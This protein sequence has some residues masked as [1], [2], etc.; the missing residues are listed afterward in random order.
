MSGFAASVER[1][2]EA[3]LRRDGP[4]ILV[5]YC[6]YA[7]EE[8]LVLIGR[9]V[10]A[11]RRDA[12]D[13]DQSRWVN[14]K[15]MASLF[16]TS[17]VGDVPVTA[18]SVTETTDAEGYVTLRV[19]R[20]KKA[21]GWVTVPA[22]IKGSADAPVEMRALVPRADAAFGVISDIDDTMMQT[23]AHNLARNLWT[24]F[25]GNALTRRVFPDALD[26][27]ERLS[28]AGRN[29]VFYVSSSPWNLHSFLNK[30]F[31]RAGLPEGPMFL[32]DLGVSGS[33]VIGASHR[34]HKGQA[35]DR[36]IAANPALNFYL[37]GDTGQKDALVYRDA[38]KRYP[39][40][41]KA[42][43]L[44][45]P[46][47]GSA[48]DSLSALLEIEAMGVPTHYARSFAN[49]PRRVAPPDGA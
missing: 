44:R 24:T 48:R 43:I 38:V 36:I 45:E 9:V 27:M 4:P 2:V 33:S 26:L 1:A 8:A 32:R 49:L 25:T 35:V 16:L 47:K 7:E 21:E 13:P 42:V 23:G 29:P 28:E 3:A 37:L 12:P 5:P 10:S 18:R 34:D 46:V 11:V 19:P 40:R 41:I 6:G 14:F 17:E 39:G 22:S 15:Q 30:V 31:D 20:P